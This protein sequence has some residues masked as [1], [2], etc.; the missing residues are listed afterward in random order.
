MTDSINTIVIG[1]GVVGLAVGRA[2]ARAGREIVVLERNSGIGEETS[3]R[4]SEVVHAGIY[5]PTGSLKQKLCV[6]GRHALY[7]FCA[8]KHVP[9]ARIGKLIVAGDSAQSATLAELASRGAHNGVDDLRLL[10]A[11]EMRRLEPAIKGE[12]ALHSPSTGIVDTHALMLALQADLESAGGVV[13]LQTQVTGADATGTKLH[14]RVRSSGEEMTLAAST[15]VNCAG[16]SAL[17]LARMWPAPGDLPPQVTQYAKGNYFTY[18]GQNPFGRL[19][20]PLPAPGGLGIHATL[21]LAARLR[22]GP[23]VE[24]TSDLDYDVDPQ[25]AASFHAAIATYW[26]QVEMSRLRPAYAGIRP[27]IVGPGERSADFMILKRTCDGGADV[28]DLLGIE[29]PG[30]TAALA[31]GDHVATMI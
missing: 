4:N 14:L 19:I 21:D 12:A 7:E 20:Y 29:S 25:R 24:W 28:I 31:I 3:G 26:P 1:A 2:L 17:S 5:Y 27:K 11:E 22:F 10:D 8:E 18:T 15:I 23:D 30:L 13:A 16:L 6:A 9:Y